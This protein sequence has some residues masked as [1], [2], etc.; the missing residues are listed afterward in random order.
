MYFSPKIKPDLQFLAPCIC[1]AMAICAMSAAWG[2]GYGKLSNGS[3]LCFLSQ[4][5]GEEGLK[6][7]YQKADEKGKIWI[8]IHVKEKW[9][10]LL[11]I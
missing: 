9:I 1:C 11:C 10:K 6:T 8:Y 3:K 4:E 7:L 5:E 2:R